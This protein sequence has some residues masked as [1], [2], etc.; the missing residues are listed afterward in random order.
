M[1]V[2]E[3]AEKE[4]KTAMVN[5]AELSQYLPQGNEENNIRTVKIAG[6]AAKLVLGSRKWGSNIPFPICLHVVVLN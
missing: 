5:S 6:T 1:T 4:K 3:S 2:N